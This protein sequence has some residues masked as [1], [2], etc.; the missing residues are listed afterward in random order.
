[1]HPILE[2]GS[3]NYRQGRP[4]GPGPISPHGWRHAFAREYLQNGGDLASLADYLGHS[5]VIA[6][7][8]CGPT[9][10]T[11]AFFPVRALQPFQSASGLRVLAAR[12]GACLRE[13][14]ATWLTDD[15][16]WISVAERG[17]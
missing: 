17:R 9:F 1:M 15:A 7:L 6:A 13:V 12:S 2:L 3:G 11:E 8:T 4:V 10:C 14:G 16:I 5:N